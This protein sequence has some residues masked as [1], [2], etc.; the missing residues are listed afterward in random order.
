MENIEYNEIDTTDNEIDL[1]KTNDR[2]K[3]S[4]NKPKINKEAL[5]EYISDNNFKKSKVVVYLKEDKNNI[6]L[7]KLCMQCEIE[8]FD[9]NTD[10]KS[11]KQLTNIC[12]Q[13]KKNIIKELSN[14][15][16]K[17]ATIKNYNKNCN[18]MYHYLI[19]LIKKHFVII[20]KLDALIKFVAELDPRTK[21]CLAIYSN[22]PC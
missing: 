4:K 19:G 17:S 9:K 11:L 2:T 6:E 16:K 1:V 10:V 5:K 15:L 8:L 21:E 20:K 22:S 13:K 7:I 14:D 18:E 12:H 3:K